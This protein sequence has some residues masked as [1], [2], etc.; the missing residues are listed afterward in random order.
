MI[1]HSPV[2]IHGL[3]GVSRAMGPER[4][5][6]E[7]LPSPGTELGESG[8]CQQLFLERKVPRQHCVEDHAH[9]P[10]VSLGPVVAMYIVLAENLPP[11]HKKK[12]KPRDCSFPPRTGHTDARC[13][14][15]SHYRPR[16]AFGLK[17]IDKVYGAFTLTTMTTVALLGREGRG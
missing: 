7:A 3:L 10:H 4:R 15:K 16:M 11:T 2:H 1:I 8:A 14:K 9:G 5:R 12:L 17:I 13:A 6:C